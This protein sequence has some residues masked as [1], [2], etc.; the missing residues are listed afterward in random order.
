MHNQNYLYVS[1]Q[2]DQSF[3][4]RRIKTISFLKVGWTSTESGH[5]IV[6]AIREI[7][8]M[9][10]HQKS[11]FNQNSLKSQTWYFFLLWLIMICSFILQK[12]YHF[13]NFIKRKWIAPSNSVT[14]VSLICAEK[15]HRV[16]EDG[17]L[18]VLFPK[19]IK[20]NQCN[21]CEYQKI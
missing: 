16:A 17:Q 19:L 20:T 9:K 4:H 7:E 3:S 6:S 2:P 13:N 5:W 18:F 11:Y 1:I 15:T 21:I 14:G 12:M 8:S 10:D